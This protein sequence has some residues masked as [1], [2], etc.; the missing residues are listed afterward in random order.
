MDIGTYSSS[1]DAQIAQIQGLTI[2]HIPDLVAAS[3]IRPS[4][5]PYYLEE[6]VG[7][8][9]TGGW[10]LNEQAIQE[11]EARS[12]IRWDAV[13]RILLT[14]PPSPLFPSE[15]LD[16]TFPIV[17]SLHSSLKVGRRIRIQYLSRSLYKFSF[18]SYS[19]MC[20]VA[21]PPTLTLIGDS[22][23]GNKEDTMM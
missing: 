17:P 19:D 5:S 2:R 12:S 8:S 3:I 21:I 14:V 22:L 6:L 11:T 9:S 18:G 23:I 1:Q 20:S 10:G 4:H 7:N 15:S 16:S 13:S